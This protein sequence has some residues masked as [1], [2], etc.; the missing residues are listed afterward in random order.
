MTEAH[1]KYRAKNM[2][3]HRADMR[4]YQ[5]KN[6][7]RIYEEYGREYMRTYHLLK[8]ALTENRMILIDE[9]Y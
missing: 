9:G 8:V 6:Y 5:A 1:K 4:K 3:R 2:E 7:K